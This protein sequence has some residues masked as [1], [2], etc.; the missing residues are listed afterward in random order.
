MPS[1]TGAANRHPDTAARAGELDPV[2]EISLP[3]DESERDRAEWRLP[4]RWMLLIQFL[5]RRPV[6][7]TLA[8]IVIFTFYQIPWG[9]I[10]A[11][12][13][14]LQPP[15][16]LTSE[17]SIRIELGGAERIANWMVHWLP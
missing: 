14:P 12:A 13:S 1:P 10:E 15:L 7:L 17:E 2:H 8:S 11:G 16:R 9:R 3:L 6:L 5:A 4:K